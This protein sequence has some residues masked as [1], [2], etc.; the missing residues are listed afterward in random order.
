MQASQVVDARAFHPPSPPPPKKKRK[1][2][3]SCA[4]DARLC[5]C[6]HEQLA[7]NWHTVFRLSLFKL[8]INFSKV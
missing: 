6:V 1:E 2:K 4:G 8:T 7:S 3:K 5:G